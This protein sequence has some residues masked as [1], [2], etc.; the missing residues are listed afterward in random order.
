M[1]IY[2]QHL[3]AKINYKLIK[4]YFIETIQKQNIF[5]NEG[6]FTLSNDNFKQIKI[7]DQQFEYITIN[8]INLICDNTII[9]YK[10]PN[11]LP[12][13]YKEQYTTIN[14]YALRKN[15]IITFNIETINDKITDV[16]FTTNEKNISHFSIQ[17]DIIFFLNTF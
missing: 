11:K 8:N 1:I 14:K 4:P 5:S 10:T 17:E 6:L 3:P 16:Y 9:H 7:S 12:F 15:S 13:H 2:L